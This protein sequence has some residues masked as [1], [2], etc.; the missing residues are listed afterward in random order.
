MDGSCT[1]CGAELQG[2]Y[3]AQCG[4]R[5]A[6]LAPSLRELWSDFAANLF[7]L[8]S[9]FARTAVALFR[10]PGQLTVEYCAGHRARYVA[11]VRLYLVSSLMLFLVLAVV[12]VQVFQA[13]ASPETRAQAAQEAKEVQ[14]PVRFWLTE[15]VEAGDGSQP[16]EPRPE[17]GTAEPGRE[18]F[19]QKAVRA[20]ENPRAVNRFILDKLPQVLFLMIPVYALLVQ[21]VHWRRRRVYAHH[22]IFVLHF[23]SLVFLLLTARVL[24]LWLPIPASWTGLLVALLV[25]SY[26]FLSLRRV[27]ETS[28][29]WTVVKMGSLLFGYFLVTAGAI[30]AL[31]FAAIYSS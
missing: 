21:L 10:R 4:Q 18:T 7:S 13:S 22:F 15:D 16:A 25:L 14:A 26:L 9:R 2:P 1:D 11:P 8:D 20:A 5:V 23:H 30:L 28:I 27:Y 12:D 19:S 24:S 6:P 3:C 31:G 29:P 17:E